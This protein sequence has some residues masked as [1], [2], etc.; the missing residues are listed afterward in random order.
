LTQ[1]VKANIDTIGT[2]EP[3]RQPAYL[4]I[5]DATTRETFLEEECD[6]K[7]EQVA[8]LKARANLLIRTSAHFGSV[9]EDLLDK[10]M[11]KGSIGSFKA[12]H[13]GDMAGVRTNKKEYEK[14]YGQLQ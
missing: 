6:A 8:G 3:H 10:T 5:I 13:G 2:K 7:E 9:A 12:S 4:T 14:L 11:T 1:F